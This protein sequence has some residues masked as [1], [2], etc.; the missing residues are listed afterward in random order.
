MGSTGVA[1]LATLLVA[2]TFGG[3]A[4]LDVSR[5][6]RDEGLIL[7]PSRS[8]PSPC[9]V[10]GRF[11]TDTFRGGLTGAL[12]AVF[13]LEL[14]VG[15]I[16]RAR[17]PSSTAGTFLA[18][19]FSWAVLL[20]GGPM[21]GRGR[22]LLEDVRRRVDEVEPLALLDER[23]EDRTLWG[24]V[25]VGDLSPLVLEPEAA[26]CAVSDGG[27]LT[28]LVGDFGFGFTKPMPE[29]DEGDS[30]IGAGFRALADGVDF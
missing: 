7:A 30:W 14:C 20:G 24:P 8:L 3:L 28:G 19:G 18:A 6:A 22:L 10:A 9:L 11:G 25:L 12:A 13:D 29:T 17:N 2:D 5:L 27:S 26:V 21:L 1:P 15:L 4:D 23:A 16:M